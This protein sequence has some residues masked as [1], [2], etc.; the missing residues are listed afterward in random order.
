MTSDFILGWILSHSP[1]YRWDF[2][3][4]T[5]DVLHPPK[6]LRGYCSTVWTNARV[7]HKDSPFECGFLRVERGPKQGMG[8]CFVL[9]ESILCWRIRD[10]KRHN[11]RRHH[12]RISRVSTLAVLQIVS[13]I[14]ALRYSGFEVYNP[15]TNSIQSYSDFCGRLFHYHTE[16]CT[17]TLTAC[18]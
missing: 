18:L 3:V 6:S 17:E 13:V 8:G 16:Y 15:F 9:P 2:P 12:K 4:G 7:V 14:S 5:F 10:V 11:K 1:W